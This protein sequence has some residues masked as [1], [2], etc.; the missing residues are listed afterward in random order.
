VY[1]QRPSV[2]TLSAFIATWFRVHVSTVSIIYNHMYAS[3]IL[4]SHLQASASS[5]LDM[6]M[7]GA[8]STSEQNHPLV[9]RQKLTCGVSVCR[10]PAVCRDFIL[11]WCHTWSLLSLHTKESQVFRGPWSVPQRDLI[12]AIHRFVMRDANRHVLRKSQ[13]LHPSDAFLLPAMWRRFPSTT[14]AARGHAANR[15][16][17]NSVE[18]CRYDR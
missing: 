7:P 9:E 10:L 18:V 6:V 15:T 4:T 14:A 11:S 16:S 2:T 12:G 13:H 3:L 5:Q 17:N 1:A 8:V